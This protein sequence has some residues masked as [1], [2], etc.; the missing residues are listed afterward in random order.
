MRALGQTPVAERERRKPMLPWVVAAI[1]FLAVGAAFVLRQAEVIAVQ[2]RLRSM[3]Q[4]IQYYTSM[5]EA[6]AKQMEV[7]KSNGYIE[8]TAREKLGLVMPGEIQYMLVAAKS[9]D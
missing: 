3:Q 9:K 4:E 7:L 8:K 6:L 2:K 5:N 1:L